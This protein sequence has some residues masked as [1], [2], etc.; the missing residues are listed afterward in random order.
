MF[1]RGNLFWQGVANRRRDVAAIPHAGS[2]ITLEFAKH[3]W[4]HAVSLHRP[5]GACQLHWA[6][7]V[8]D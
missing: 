5:S 2:A 6:P 3:A 8:K 1:E 7:D 4:H